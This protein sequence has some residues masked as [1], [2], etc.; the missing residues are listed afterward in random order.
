MHLRLDY[1]RALFCL[2]L[3]RLHV[4]RGAILHMM[5]IW[6]SGAIVWPKTGCLFVV[7]ADRLLKRAADAMDRADGTCHDES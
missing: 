7:G 1:D 5:L 4:Y 2:A 3:L 6:C